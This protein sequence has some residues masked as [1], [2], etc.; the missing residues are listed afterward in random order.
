MGDVRIPQGSTSL[1]R[2]LGSAA[3]VAAVAI[4]FLGNMPDVGLLGSL[5]SIT[6][7]IRSATGLNQNWRV[8]SP[9][10]D[11]SA[12]VEARVDYS[13]G[14]ASVYSIP[15]RPGIGTLVDYRWQKYME[16]IRPDAGE[17]YWPAFAEYVANRARAEGRDP[18]H[19]TVIRR[20]ADTL[21]PGPGP[22]R[23]PWHEYTMYA[24]GVE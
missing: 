10:R 23:G 21:P 7:P 17:P 8:Y 5:R 4:I 16:V 13:D 22:E 9:P 11:I 3:L 14:T 20:W 15:D 19:V 12:Y 6:Q 24:M 18:V 2:A 1:R